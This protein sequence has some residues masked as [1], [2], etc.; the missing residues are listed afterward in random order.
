MFRKPTPVASRFARTVLAAGMLSML[1]VQCNR[2]K[3]EEGPPPTEAPTPLPAPAPAVTT[4]PTTISRSDLIGAAGQAASTY[5]LGDT[6]SGVDPLVGRTFSV[7]IPFGCAGPA[8]PS[9]GGGSDGLAHWSWGQDRKSIQISMT[10][11]DWTESSLVRP[12][13][14]AETPGGGPA[15]EAVEGFWIPRPWLASEACPAVVRDPLQTAQAPVSPQ[16]VGIAAVFEPDGSR[17]GRRNGRAYTHVVRAQGDAPLEAPV[18]GYRLRLEGRIV[19][20]PGGRALRCQAE[21]ADQRP[22]CVAA[23]QL[24]KAA[25]EDAVGAT[26]SEWRLG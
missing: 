9:G 24:D 1:L 13:Q 5:A 20:F 14:S 6:P 10:P 2:P 21:R 23:V 3:G 15:W 11:G 26:L 7:L 18:G 12:M 4:R 17:L 22:V 8:D 16:T 25:F 19:G